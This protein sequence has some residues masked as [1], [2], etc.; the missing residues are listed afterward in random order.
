MRSAAGVGSPL[1]PRPE[2]DR[3]GE[4]RVSTVF[5]LAH[6]TV[7]DL[8]PA[9]VVQVAARTAYQSVGLRL[10]AVTDTTPGYPLMEDPPTM[11]DTKSA[12]ADTAVRVLDIELVKVT[13]E[14]DV[15]GLV[16]A[17]PR[18]RRPRN[19]RRSLVCERRPDSPGKPR[20]RSRGAS[21]RQPDRDRLEGREPCRHEPA[22]EGACPSA[23]KGT[24][25]G[26]SR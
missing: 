3:R 26:S 17:D 1:R 2:S 10:L 18:G 16:A 4:S 23:I 25:G 19:S 6:L 7:L 24:G 13:P 20:E 22:G 11:R 21:M 14:I 15:T 5:S 9:E 12:F 8:P